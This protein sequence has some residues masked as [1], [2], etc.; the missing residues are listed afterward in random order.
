MEAIRPFLISWNLT[1]R[2]NL[3]C[4]HCYI[5]ADALPD[6][7]D[8]AGG[9]TTAEAQGI[10]D[11]IA[12]AAP[13]AMLILT[14]GEPL[15]RGDIFEI[16]EYA[17]NR[18]LAVVI[19]TNGTLVDDAAARRMKEAG[20]IGAGVSI[21]SAGPGYHDR[22]RGVRG[23]WDGAM[24]GARALKAAGVD[25]QVQFS[26][27]R[28]NMDELQGM[29]ELARTLGAR[30]LNVFFL[31]CTG[32][33]QEMTDL[34]PEEYERVLERI[35]DLAAEEAP[36]DMMVRARCA[37]HLMRIAGTRHPES[38]ITRGAT[39]G[40]IA[41]RGYLRITPE[42]RVTPCPYIPELESSPVV[43][44]T[45]LMGAIAADERFAALAYP[46]Y[47]GRCGRCEYRE[48]CGG[49]RARALASSDTG[50]ITALMDEDPW[51]EYLPAEADDAEVK[52][53][54]VE[55]VWTEA[56]RERLGRVP[57]FLRPMIKKGVEG[58]ARHKGIGEITPEIMTEM[59][60]K[61]G[62]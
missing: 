31:V 36:G 60:N 50:G 47:N 61:A 16:I 35:A 44:E 42:G 21:D 2:C 30:A 39:S 17:S 6:G 51:C 14:G 54:A 57:V 46:E 18:G 24:R 26:V 20:A 55:P 5:D 49:C 13:G 9:P 4:A 38:P 58:Y 40:C 56:A 32:R 37:P 43:T 19:G 8:E 53:P 48:S 10:I 52:A 12:G 7:G 28:A 59:R 25:L 23:A 41:G 1:R 15:L 33:G 62:R 34:T 3:E 22:L 11:E 29:V 45:G 27:T